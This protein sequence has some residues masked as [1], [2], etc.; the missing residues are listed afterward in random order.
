MGNYHY[1]AANHGRDSKT[2][3]TWESTSNYLHENTS[4]GVKYSAAQKDALTKTAVNSYEY[5]HR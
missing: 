4:G 1:H 3:P 5:F 2:R